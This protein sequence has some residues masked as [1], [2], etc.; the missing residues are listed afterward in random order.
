MRLVRAP[1]Y[2]LAATV[3]LC[4]G[5]PDPEAKFGEF[6]DNTKDDRDFVPVQPDIMPATADISGQFLLAVTPKFA[7]GTPLQMI[8]TNTLMTDGAGNTIL[9][10]SMQ[11]LS[12]DSLKVTTPRMPVGDP[13][14]QEMIPVVDGAFTI[15]TGMVMFPGE[16]NPLTGSPIVASLVLSGTIVG[17][18]FYCGTI[19]GTV[20]EPIMQDM[21]GSTF[22]AVRL[23]ATDP[24]S[25]PKM[26]TQNCNGDTVTDPP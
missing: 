21:E 14:M 1:R 5:C 20:T 10:S 16:A 7:P 6:V 12:L 15:D 19:T 3:L 2:L 9:S 4:A 26:V 18:D 17:T 8:A 22:A 11:P 23:Q 13:L 25:L 24:A